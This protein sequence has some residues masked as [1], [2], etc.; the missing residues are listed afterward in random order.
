MCNAAA[1]LVNHVFPEVPVRQYVLSAPFELR[2]LLA[3]DA[4]AYGALTRIFAEEVIREQRERAR[5]L[6][7]V[8][9]RSAGIS[10]QQRWG[11]SINLNPHVHA[12]WCDGVFTKPEESATRTDT[13]RAQF[14]RLPAPAAGELERIVLRIH[15]RIVRW[16]ARHDLLADPDLAAWSNVRAERTSIDACLEGALGIG[17]LGRIDPRHVAKGDT[18]PRSGTRPTPRLR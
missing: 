15:E 17:H 4:A 18:A 13:A 5:Q 11:S 12:A 1:H 9:V 14:Q 10:V 2:L 3:R 6:G 7:I 8:A 16:L